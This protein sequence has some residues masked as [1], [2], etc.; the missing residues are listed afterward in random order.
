MISIY[1]VEP[2]F[3]KAFAILMMADNS[4]TVLGQIGVSAVVQVGSLQH[5]NNTQRL[6]KQFIVIVGNKLHNGLLHV[7][8]YACYFAVD[9][10]SFMVTI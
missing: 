5:S 4:G 1:I 9:C 10:T 7:D 8:T 6:E 3:L 2:V